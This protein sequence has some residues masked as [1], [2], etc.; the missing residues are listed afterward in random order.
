MGYYGLDDDA[1]QDIIC[2]FLMPV[3]CWWN[4]KLVLFLR[5]W[6]V[7]DGC[8]RSDDNATHGT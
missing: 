8:T 6:L 7:F 2:L 3:I 5:I 4:T 1:M